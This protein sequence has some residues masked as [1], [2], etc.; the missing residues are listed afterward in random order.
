MGLSDDER[1]GL[2]PH[3]ERRFQE[4][5]FAK[6]V[7]HFRWTVSFHGVHKLKALPKERDAFLAALLTGDLVSEVA[8]CAN[9]F[10]GDELEYVVRKIEASGTGPSWV[11]LAKSRPQDVEAWIQPRFLRWVRPSEYFR[12]NTQ[13]KTDCWPDVLNWIQQSKSPNLVPVQ[14]L[15]AELG[16]WKELVQVTYA[17]DYVDMFAT[18][19]LQFTMPSNQDR[20]D[21]I[22]GSVFSLLLHLTGERRQKCL[23][24]VHGLMKFI[25]QSGIWKELELWQAELLHSIQHN[26]PSSR[27]DWDDLENFAV[28]HWTM[29]SIRLYAHHLHSSKC[30]PCSPVTNFLTVEHIMES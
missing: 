13:K 26:I 19:Y 22:D 7:D 18:L 1:R 6:K 28:E 29:K 2:P 17:Y 20:K 14:F 5:G 16:M 30:E 8:R 25:G 23:D 10:E 11:A 4:P 21:K 27:F 24:L 9:F 15:M 3:I 12:P